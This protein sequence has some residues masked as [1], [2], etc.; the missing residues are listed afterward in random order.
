MSI[1]FLSPDTSATS[2]I[3]RIL[4]I[5]FREEFNIC[6]AVKK[7]HTSNNITLTQVMMGEAAP[8]EYGHLFF[9]KTENWLPE[10]WISAKY[11]Y[12]V[13]FRDPRDRLCNIF[14]WFSFPDRPSKNAVA[15]AKRMQ[16]AGIDKWVKSRTTMHDGE[17]KQFGRRAY[18]QLFRVMEGFSEQCLVNTY[19]RLCLDFDSFIHRL[20]RFTGIPVT[21]PMWE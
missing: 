12:I 14:H 2:S 10:S 11:R 6:W 13:N 7:W 21:K 5:I 1:I 19:A 20:S 4:D 15:G 3:V 17:H 18:N 8:P 16:K 9:T